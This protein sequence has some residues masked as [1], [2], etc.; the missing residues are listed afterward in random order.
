M[1]PARFKGATRKLLSRYAQDLQL[2]IADG[3]RLDMPEYSRLLR[4]LEVL[5]AATV[6]VETEL[7]GLG[8]QERS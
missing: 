1:T 2:M 6:K 4:D 8:R 5:Q 7:G 3:Y